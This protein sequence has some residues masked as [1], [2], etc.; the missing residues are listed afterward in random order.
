MK[1]AKTPALVGMLVAIL[2]AAAIPLVRTPFVVNYGIRAYRTFSYVLAI[3][4]VIAFAF[5]LFSLLK[6][7]K[8]ERKLGEARAEYESRKAME[9]VKIPKLPMKGKLKNHEL[10]KILTGQIDGPWFDVAREGDELIFQ[11]KQMDVYQDKLAALLAENDATALSDA[12]NLLDSVEQYLCRNVRKVLNYMSVANPET[13][14]DM[15][16][17]RMEECKKDNGDR[18]KQTQEF[19]YAMTEYLNG[20]GEGTADVDA[21]NMYKM[22]LLESVREEKS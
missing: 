8:E 12:E 1:N 6:R 21:M 22:A 4:C 2:G 15:I 7:T 13:D 16:R 3:A 19:I 5:S 9:N 10:R 11:M 18:L 20:Q 14:S 17:D